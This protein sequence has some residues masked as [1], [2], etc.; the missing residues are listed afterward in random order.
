MKILSIKI[1]CI[2]VVYFSLFLINIWLRIIALM[3]IFVSYNS[4]KPFWLVVFIF[5]REDYSFT[6]YATISYLKTGPKA[7]LLNNEAH[8]ITMQVKKSTQTYFGIES[9]QTCHSEGSDK[10]KEGKNSG[11]FQKKSANI[12]QQSDTKNTGAKKRKID[13]AWDE[14]F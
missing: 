1:N 3:V 11:N 6:A 5:C 4:S 2:F 14:C 10:K 7:H 8:V 9:S 12:L 13:D